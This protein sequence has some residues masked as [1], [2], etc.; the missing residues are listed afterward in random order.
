MRVLI[1]AILIEEGRIH[2]YSLHKRILHYTHMRW[3]PSIGTIYRT[4]NEMVGE[5]L[6]I[7]ST[8]G[9]RHHYTIT[10]KGV[11]YFIKYSKAPATKMA[12]ILIT[13][14]EAYF[15]IIDERPDVLTKD[16]RERLRTLREVLQ[17]RD[18]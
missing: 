11:E 5:G 17:K 3:K 8:E 12:G 13:I 2:G 16:L 9:R 7:K 15:K 6:I 18:I 10:Q 14:L 1:L 4:L